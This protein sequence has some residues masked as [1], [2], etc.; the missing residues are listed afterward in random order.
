MKAFNL[1]SDGTV[2]IDFSHVTENPLINGIEIVRTDRAGAAAAG[3]N[4]ALTTV[5]FDGTNA[6]AT[7]AE[8]PGHRLRQL[9]RRLHGRQQGL[10]RLHRR[11]PVLAHVQRHD[12]RPGREDRPVQR[13]GLGERRQPATARRSTGHGA[14]PL[15]PDP[16]HHRHGLPRAAGCTTRCS[17]TRT[18]TRA[19]STRTA[20]SST[21]PPPTAASSVELQQRRRHVHLG[22]HA[23]LRLEQRRRPAPGARSATD[24]TVSG[25]PAVVS[26]PTVD[27]VNWTNRAM[28]LASATATLP[29]RGVHVELHE[30]ELHV[31]RRRPRTT[32]TVR[33]TATPGPS[34]TARRAPAPRRRTPTRRPARTPSR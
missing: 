4:D 29:D 18:C 34:A 3:A 12:V 11:L 9:A 33:S 26:G 15:R 28:F 27:G 1:T 10:L 24:G 8:Q 21:R 22:R 6:T 20:G 13:P 31:Q 5:A 32:P 30:P 2:N 23:V 17:A 25:T 19:G 16:E 7:A 14:R